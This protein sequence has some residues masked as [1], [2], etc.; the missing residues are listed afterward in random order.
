[1]YGVREFEP[2]SPQL[3]VVQVFPLPQSSSTIIVYF[4]SKTCKSFLEQRRS[5][6]STN[7]SRLQRGTRIE[8][9]FDRAKNK[10]IRVRGNETNFQGAL[11]DKDL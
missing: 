9:N 8:K 5:N 11:R 10:S 4:L 6:L 7:S 3:I 1:M 2:F